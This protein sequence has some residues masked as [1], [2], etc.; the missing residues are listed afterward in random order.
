MRRYRRR[1]QEF[2]PRA[3]PW[4]VCCIQCDAGEVRSFKPSFA[5][6]PTGGSAYRRPPVWRAVVRPA[7]YF[8][9]GPKSPSALR[10]SASRERSGRRQKAWFLPAKSGP[11]ESRESV[12]AAITASLRGSRA[13]DS[14]LQLRAVF[15]AIFQTFVF[16][17][18]VSAARRLT[19]GT[20]VSK[21]TGLGTCRSKPASMAAATSPL[22]A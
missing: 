8:L 21:S 13:F 5:L 9:M 10:P 16:H 15:T 7:R 6:T 12:S 14:R 4:H 3:W 11:V 22:E 1:A 20:K 2:F 17:C 18:R 19:I